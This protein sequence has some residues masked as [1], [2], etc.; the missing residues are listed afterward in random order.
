[1]SAKNSHLVGL[2]ITIGVSLLIAT[3]ISLGIYFYMYTN[4]S[5]PTLL[6]VKRSETA[7]PTVKSFSVYAYVSREVKIKNSAD[8]EK[9]ISAALASSIPYHKDPKAPAPAEG[10]PAEDAA[11]AKEKAARAR[12]IGY[13]TKPKNP[14]E[15]KDLHGFKVKHS[16][17]L[18]GAKLHGTDK[19]DIKKHPFG[20][21]I[22]SEVEEQIFQAL[23]QVAND[24]YPLQKLARRIYDYLTRNTSAKD[25]PKDEMKKFNKKYDESTKK[26]YVRYYTYRTKIEKKIKPPREVFVKS[27]NEFYK[28]PEGTDPN[29]DPN[30]FVDPLGKDEKE[31]PAPEEYDP[32]E[33]DAMS[34][35]ILP[36]SVK[37]AHG[38]PVAA[39]KPDRP[40]YDRAYLIMTE[41]EV[42]YLPELVR[43]KAI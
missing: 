4:T 23:V 34:T 18:L 36:E 32:P 31:D 19:D 17:V 29:T 2:L 41:E 30:E 38:N 8:S 28:F 3:G 11:L 5:Y 21:S 43:A 10:A 6:A 37:D 1:M 20:N 33:S 7:E 26:R 13:K 15:V 39:K 35:L 27:T 9:H 25:V 14:F 42:E 24:K 40:V 22:S 12:I 16:W